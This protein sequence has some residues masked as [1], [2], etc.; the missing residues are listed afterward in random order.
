MSPVTGKNLLVGLPAEVGVE[1]AVD[2]AVAGPL[3]VGLG[4]APVELAVAVA[5]APVTLLARLLPV[6]ESGLH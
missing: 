1:V 3:E 4:R 2:A 6:K 5:V